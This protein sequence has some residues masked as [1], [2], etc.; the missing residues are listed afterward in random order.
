MLEI[1]VAFVN[2]G[3]TKPDDRIRKSIIATGVI[4]KPL[5]DLTSIQI[6]SR[7]IQL[8]GK[9]DFWSRIMGSRRKKSAAKIE[10]LR[11]RVR[12]KPIPDR[13]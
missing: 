11:G 4:V 7:S 13:W 3:Y 8:V 10:Y 6:S 1:P 12:R 9:M 5:C 2:T